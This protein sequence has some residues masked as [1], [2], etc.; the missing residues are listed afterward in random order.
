MSPIRD[1]FRGSELFNRDNTVFTLGDDRFELPTFDSKIEFLS[2]MRSK[3]KEMSVKIFYDQIEDNMQWFTDFYA[4]WE[5]IK[6]TRSDRFAHFMSYIM[7]TDSFL[8]LVENELGEGSGGFMEDFITHLN[9]FDR[10][11]PCH[12]SFIYE[13]I[14]D[15]ILWSYFGLDG[16]ISPT[17]MDYFNQM[18]VGNKSNKDYRTECKYYDS[19]RQMFYTVLT[20][21]EDSNR[22]DRGNESTKLE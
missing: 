9:N 22:L 20:D 2:D 8:E 6:L 17:N 10:F 5:I 7:H 18:V 11:G 14:N 13:D 16:K 19:I 12:H 4:D 1:Q 15:E 21:M 3:G